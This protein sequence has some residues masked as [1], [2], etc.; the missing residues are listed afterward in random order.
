MEEPDFWDQPE[1]SQEYMK[2][3]SSLKDDIEI[4][5]KL[6][7]QYEEIETLLEMAYEEND[8]SL[9]PE[10]E[11]TL[12]DFTTSLE[13]IRISARSE[14][15]KCFSTV[16]PNDPVPPVIINVLFLKKRDVSI[17]ISYF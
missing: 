3:L 15:K 17:C 11:E 2:T 5:R 7:D 1:K 9:I 10:I 4:F 6:N 13:N 16:E 12:N 14:S 8:A